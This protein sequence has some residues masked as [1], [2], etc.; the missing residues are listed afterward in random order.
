M[1][2]GL[3]KTSNMYVGVKKTKDTSYQ[4]IILTYKKS[5]AKKNSRIVMKS[6]RVEKPW[7]FNS[8]NMTNIKLQL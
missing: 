1:E 4:D 8:K 2:H 7:F 3:K 5:D 6:K